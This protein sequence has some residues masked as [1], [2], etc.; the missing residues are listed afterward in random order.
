[1]KN[2]SKS[3]KAQT[4]VKN[5]QQS[6]TGSDDAIHAKRVEAKKA[7]RAEREANEHK[8]S[9]IQTFLKKPAKCKGRG[10]KRPRTPSG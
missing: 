3:K 4:F 10:K 8:G 9:A 5:V 1:M 2:K 6:I 7:A